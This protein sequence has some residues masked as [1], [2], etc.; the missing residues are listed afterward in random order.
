[1]RISLGFKLKLKY[2]KDFNVTHVSLNT[3]RETKRD[4][5]FSKIPSV[6]TKWSVTDEQMDGQRDPSKS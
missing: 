3:K 1:M 5:Y 6:M 2:L 4:V